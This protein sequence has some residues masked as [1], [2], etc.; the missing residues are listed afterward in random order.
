MVS[1]LVLAIIKEA[2]S[3]CSSAESTWLCTS[4]EH[5]VRRWCSACDGRH[6]ARTLDLGLRSDL[7]RGGLILG[8]IEKIFNAN[9]GQSKSRAIEEGE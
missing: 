1:M 7:W 8:P 3:P 5:S 2:A 4:R 9:F 6:S